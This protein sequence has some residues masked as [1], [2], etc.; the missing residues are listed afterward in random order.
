MKNEEFHPVLRYVCNHQFT[1]PDAAERA[2]EKETQRLCV[3]LWLSSSAVKQ[4]KAN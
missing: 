3:C 1:A 4:Q 2:A